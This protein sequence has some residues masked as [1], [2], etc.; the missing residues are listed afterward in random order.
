MKVM[1]LLTILSFLGT[2]EW[3][4]IL[5]IFTIG[6]GQLLLAGIG[7]T[8]DEISNKLDALNGRKGDMEGD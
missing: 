1:G 3:L 7:N 6:M 5:L 4:L 8:L 2:T